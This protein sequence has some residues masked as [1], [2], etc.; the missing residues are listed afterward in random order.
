M[1]GV[2]EI[3][4]PI[5]AKEMVGGLTKVVVS[6]YPM[7]MLV[8]AETITIASKAAIGFLLLNLFCIP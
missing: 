7:L 6:A 1:A 3:L 5:F 2:A 4:P 8:Y